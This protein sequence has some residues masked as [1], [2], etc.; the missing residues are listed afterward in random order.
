MVLVIGSVTVRAD[1]VE[2]A[3]GLC[4]RHVDRSRQE[5]G[6][7]RHGVHVDNE[8]ACRLVFVEYWQDIEHLEE[9][10]RIPESLDFVK[11]LGTLATSAPEMELFR[12][13]PLAWP[14]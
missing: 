12:S 2:E 7:I 13:S 8:D 6:C 10:F 14:P 4:Q 5:A 9:H 11:R 3:L 1:A